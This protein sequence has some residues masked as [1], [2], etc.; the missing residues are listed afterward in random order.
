MVHVVAPTEF[1]RWLAA[2]RAD[3]PAL[4]RDVYAK[5]AGASRNVAPRAYG[6]VDPG[7][8]EQIRIAAPPDRTMRARD[9]AAPQAD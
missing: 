5:L 4:S 9:A 1:E 6:A 3:L 7:L 2:T 8:F